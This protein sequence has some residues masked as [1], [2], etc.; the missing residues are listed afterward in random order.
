MNSDYYFVKAKMQDLKREEEKANQ[1]R[2]V[3]KKKGTKK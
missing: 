3:N 2:K 1:N